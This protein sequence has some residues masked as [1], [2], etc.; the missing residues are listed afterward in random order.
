M[1]RNRYVLIADLAIFALAALGAFV[2]RFDWFFQP[3]QQEFVWFACAALAVKPLVFLAY[4]MYGRYWPFASIRDFLALALAVA[5]STVVMGLFIGGILVTHVIEQFAR[6]VV[7]IDALLTLVMTGGFRIS[8]RIWFESRNRTVN[9]P[10]SRVRRV[11][12]VGA[13]EAGAMVARELTRNPQRLMMPL[14]FVDD[15]QAKVG[16]RIYGLPVFGPLSVLPAVIQS[17]QINEVAIAMPSASGKII[18]EI[19]E[20]CRAIGV[21]SRVMPG[22]F[23]LLDGNVDVSRLRKVDIVDLLRR[24]EVAWNSEAGSYLTDR[25]V[26]VTGAGGSIGLELCRQVAQRRP[27]ALVLFGHGENSLFEAEA[28]LRRVYPELEMRVVV[29]DVREAGRVSR[30]FAR[31]KPDVVFHAAAHKHV[32]LME[33]NPEEAISNNVLGTRNV[34][35]AAADA[36]AIR[37]VLISTDKAVSPSSLMGASKRVAEAVVR[38]A[39]RRFGRA[40]VVV[41]FGNVLGSQGSVVPT[42][43]RQ[44]RE[45]GPVTVTHPDMRRYFMTIPEAVHLVLEAGGMGRGGEL[46]VLRMGEPVRIVDLARDL[47]RLSGTAADGIEIEYTGIRPGEKLEEELWEPGSATT[48]TTNPEVLEVREP[49][50]PE[51]ATLQTLLERFAQAVAQ[52]NAPAVE[53]LLGEAIPTFARSRA[54]THR[55]Q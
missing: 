19:A 27:K 33:T 22:V 24:E 42:F 47:I 45:G 43:A 37:F 3:F 1:T 55:H 54:Q 28:H 50:S 44:I 10:R 14:G 18:R 53:T 9:V 36:G 11:L 7:L 40:F 16:K 31:E 49:D 25:T 48:P 12:I 8:L 17:Q 51:P 52:G 6:S 41:R 30:I 21:A 4:G 32:P 34:V 26:L 13:G 2:L 35:H 5:T 39:A 15:D 29:A 46:F 23:E 20:V 38:D